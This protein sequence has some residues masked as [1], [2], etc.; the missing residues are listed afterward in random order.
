MLLTLGPKG[1]TP[2]TWPPPDW[3]I[4]PFP[5]PPPWA[6]G[7]LDP[8]RGVAFGGPQPEPPTSP[9]IMIKIE[10]HRMMSTYLR[11]LADILDKEAELAE[12]D[13]R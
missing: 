7:P 5:P 12:R 10:A 3:R 4:G 9:E 8:R 11:E 13:S 2:P 6:V 1:P